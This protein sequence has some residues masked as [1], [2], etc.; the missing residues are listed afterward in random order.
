MQQTPTPQQRQI[1]IDRE[2]ANDVQKIELATLDVSEIVT[3]DTRILNKLKR[4][5]GRRK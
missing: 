4:K 2:H 1:R 5:M 3:I